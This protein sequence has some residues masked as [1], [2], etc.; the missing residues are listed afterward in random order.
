[1][2]EIECYADKIELRLMVASNLLSYI[3]YIVG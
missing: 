3:D 1:M 2:S